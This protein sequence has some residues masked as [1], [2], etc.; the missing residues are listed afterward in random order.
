MFK[1]ADGWVPLHRAIMWLAH[2]SVCALLG[3]LIVMV[4]VLLFLGMLVTLPVWL[5]ACLLYAGVAKV[6][7]H[8][9]Q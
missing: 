6:V 9:R 1:G 2:E 4:G 8:A 7:Q 3:T 5:P